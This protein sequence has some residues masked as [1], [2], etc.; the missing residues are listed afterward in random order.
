MSIALRAFCHPS[1]EPPVASEERGLRPRNSLKF[2]CL[3]GKTDA[4]STR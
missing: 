3:L 1:D 4:L 2:V